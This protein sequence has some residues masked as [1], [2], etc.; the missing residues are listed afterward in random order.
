MQCQS[1][2]FALYIAAEFF[3]GW[4]LAPCA[5]FF[6]GAL[7][8]RLQS[9]PAARAPDRGA[10]QNT[11]MC[12]VPSW[13]CMAEAAHWHKVT[14]WMAS[15]NSYMLFPSANAITCKLWAGQPQ[16]SHIGTSSLCT[17]RVHIYTTLVP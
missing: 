10:T 13:P 16:D 5:F 1:L 8:S 3:F 2:F 11:A 15:E 7:V 14:C 17:A 12:S 4:N 6:A 9:R